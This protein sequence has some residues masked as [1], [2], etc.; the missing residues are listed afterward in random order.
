[1][2]RLLSTLL[3]A[4]LSVAAVAQPPP[5]PPADP[6]WSR[7]E[8]PIYISFACDG[9]FVY[10]ESGGEWGGTKRFWLDDE[11]VVREVEFSDADSTFVGEGYRARWGGGGAFVERDG[12][13][14]R[15]RCQQDRPEAVKRADGRP[16]LRLAWARMNPK[17]LTTPLVPRGVPSTM[18][19]TLFVGE[20]ILVLDSRIVTVARIVQDDGG[21]RVLLGFELTP[22]A[23]TH[24]KEASNEH[25]RQPLAVLHDGELVAA[26]MIQRPIPGPGVVLP[27]PR[28]TANAFLDALDP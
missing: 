11:A 25:M 15:D 1:M 12:V 8:G 4:C 5:P 10:F 18:Q 20:D 6:E 22:E 2:L 21:R 19:N 27:V 28:E 9:G 14:I 26:P 23:A 17:P 16:G 24:L 13:R 7:T 3:L